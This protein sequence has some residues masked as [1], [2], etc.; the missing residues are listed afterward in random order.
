MSITTAAS[1]SQSAL[2]ATPRVDPRGMRFAAALTA[3][4]L[5]AVL[6]TES[7]VLLAV[8]AVVF[9]I[10]AFSGVR[11]SPYA[12]VFAKVVRPR[13]GPPRETED[14]R[15]PRFAQGVGF[16]FAVVG[17]LGFVIG[18]TPLALTATAFALAAAF[19]NA[20]FGL[21]LGCEFYLIAK[22]NFPAQSRGNNTPEVSA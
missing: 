18:S 22:R 3:V 6:V 20:V 8:Q 1:D 11:R 13:L 9:A 15:P 19:L 21:C 16:G 14:A 10:G 4:V 5:A 12:V 2:A 17:L 7:W